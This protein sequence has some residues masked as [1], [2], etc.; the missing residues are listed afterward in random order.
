MKTFLN[1]ICLIVAMLLSTLAVSAYDF[2]V[3]GIYYTITSTGDLTCGVAGCESGLNDLVIPETVSYMNRVLKVTSICNGAFSGASINIVQL[4]NT[5][6]ALGTACFKNSSITSILNTTSISYLGLGCFAGCRN[7]EQFE[8]SKS[9]HVTVCGECFSDCQSLKTI[10]IP[11]NVTL[12]DASNFGN[13]FQGCTGL[14]EVVIDCVTLP[15]STFENC[16]FLKTVKLGENC[17]SLGRNCF[18][19]CSSLVNINLPESIEKIYSNCFA[20][21]TS[22]KTIHIP[23]SVTL[24]EEPGLSWSSGGES[25]FEGCTSLENVEWN[26][27][28][29][30]LYAFEGCEALLS[31]TIGANTSKIYLGSSRSEYSEEARCTFGNCNLQLLRLLAS[32]KRIA[33][34]YLHVFSGSMGDYN[35]I[36]SHHYPDSLINVFLKLPELYTAREIE[37]FSW[38]ENKVLY[39]SLKRLTLGMNCSHSITSNLGGKI[40]WQGLEYLA[41][42]NPVPPNLYSSFGF[43]TSQY[44][45]MPVYVPEEAIETYMQADV[46]KDFWNLKGVSAVNK[47]TQDKSEMS[48]IC[49]NGGFQVRNKPNDK[50]VNVFS[51]QGTKVEET[52]DNEVLNLVPGIYIVKVADNTFKIL[53]K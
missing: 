37:G 49:V 14:E 47:V 30:P 53:V 19:N 26:A 10:E 20:N 7:I 9:K 32:E 51:I 13:F 25:M 40:A 4:P 18:A 46:W 3:D 11:A 24:S 34:L 27:N 44:T 52:Y 41:S 31:L 23:Q 21:C 39:P 28:V 43:T 29:I 42:E 8:F 48:I 22:L 16:S 50:L 35:S 33:L 36:E 45:T 15:Q 12:D 5:I 17:I 1:R 2:E 38:Q 6:T